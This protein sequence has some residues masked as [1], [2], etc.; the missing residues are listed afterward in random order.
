MDLAE[1]SYPEP[2]RY[3]VVTAFNDEGFELY[4]KRM[5]EGYL[6]YWPKS[7]PLIVYPQGLNDKDIVWLYEQ[8][9]EVREL[10]DW[11]HVFVARHRDT[12]EHHGNLPTHYDF[13]C[14][15][16]KWACKPAAIADALERLIDGVL[17]WLDAD[18]VMKKPVSEEWLDGLFPNPDNGM[19]WLDR[20]AKAQE[21]SF[22]MFRVAFS[23]SHRIVGE[24]RR[25]YETDEV[26]KL[27]YTA[28]NYV[29]QH[30]VDKMGLTPVS[31]SGSGRHNNEPFNEGPLGDRILHLKGP[32]AKYRSAPRISDAYRE[33]QVKMHAEQPLY[34]TYGRRFARQLEDIAIEHRC[35]SLLDYGA[36]KGTLKQALKDSSCRQLTD[37]REYDPA[38][39][40][41]DGEPEPADLVV[42]GDVL[43]H[44]EADKIAAVLEHIRRLTLRV[45]F[46]V[47]HTQESTK[48]MPTGENAHILMRD[49]DWWAIT[50][51]HYFELRKFDVGVREISVVVSPKLYEPNVIT[52]AALDDG[53]RLRQARANMKR[54]PTRLEEAPPHD[55][56]AVI[57]CYGPSLKYTW[58][59]VSRSGDKADVF[60]V[61]G[62][63]K[64]LID[65]GV[66][67]H[68]H[69]DC[70]PREHKAKQFGEPHPQVQYWLASCVH[71]AYL[72]RLE[73]RAVA[74]W[75]LWNGDETKGLFDELEPG[76]W[77]V[78]GGGSVGLRAL[79]LLYAMGYRDFEIHGMDCSYAGGEKYA[80]QH[81]GKAH[82]DLRIRCGDRWFDT[83]A[84]MVAYAQQ[85][86]ITRAVMHDA[87]VRL[88][89][90]GLLQHMVRMQGEVDAGRA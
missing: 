18:T 8:G 38:V 53:I 12:P 42:C 7:I 14:N 78:Q 2:R 40:G 76:E 82:H 34:G 69:I 11:W 58:P 81:F 86:F 19:A 22:L 41:I 54:V 74:L 56:T 30:V 23:E 66:I 48:Q 50:L 17:I 25:L 51:S 84:S 83:G 89:G 85:F 10:P 39:S 32:M 44:V 80:G 29:L 52:F 5:I 88:H 36:G 28:D 60:S 3:R 26:F 79:P 72:D 67:P 65:H 75:H 87:T 33:M 49:P 4:G 1:Q 9:V 24:F 37:I 55:R 77:L 35:A 70:D 21:G 64:F 57:V 90:D 15:A 20:E 45:G 16:V 61:S 68:I 62:A 6:R 27:Q 31:L 71:P 73:G 43:E 47:I 46:L 59:L 13:R 63:H